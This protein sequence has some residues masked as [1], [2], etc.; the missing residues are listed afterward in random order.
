M[1][2]K[3]NYSTTTEPGTITELGIERLGVHRASAERSASNLCRRALQSLR[4][5]CACLKA[6]CRECLES[7]A[8]AGCHGSQ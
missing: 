2:Y 1:Q 4:W 8:G 6:W 7:R 5:T 3:V